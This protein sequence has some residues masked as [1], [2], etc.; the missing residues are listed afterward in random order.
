MPRRTHPASAGGGQLTWRLALREPMLLI[1]TLWYLTLTAWLLLNS[2]LVFAEYSDKGEAVAGGAAPL[3]ILAVLF[4]VLVLGEYSL[5]GWLWRTSI[6]DHNA[7]LQGTR[8]LFGSEATH[9]AHLD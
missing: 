5:L 6:D 7:R 1:L 4:L 2:L 8:D 3:L 9:P